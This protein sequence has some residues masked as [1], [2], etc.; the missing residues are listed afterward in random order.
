M[1]IDGACHCG[2]ITYE[3]EIDAEQVEVC[4][5]TDRIQTFCPRCGSAIYSATGDTPP[6]S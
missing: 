1:K 4:H 3:A 6:T 2:L 5:C